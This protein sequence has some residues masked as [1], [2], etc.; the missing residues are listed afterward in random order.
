MRAMDVYDEVAQNYNSYGIDY[1]R[2]H[3]GH[4]LSVLSGHDNPLLYSENTMILEEKMVIT[5]E[6]ILPCGR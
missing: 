2:D 3:I 6:L 5:L 1:K 4:S